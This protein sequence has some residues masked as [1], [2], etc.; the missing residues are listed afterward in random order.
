MWGSMTPRQLGPDDPH[1]VFLSDLGDPFFEPL[2]PSGPDSPNPDE[3]MMMPAHPSLPALLHEAGHSG[4]RS[5]NDREAD[6]CRCVADMGEARQIQGFLPIGV[7][8][9]E[10]PVRRFRG[11]S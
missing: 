3:R 1:A 4:G 6:R 2:F 7:D 9:I 8:E 10:G 11:D 5:N